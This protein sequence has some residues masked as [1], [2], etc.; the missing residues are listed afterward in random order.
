MN[1]YIKNVILV[2]NLVHIQLHESDPF[3]KSF[4]NHEAL[5]TV[6][7][8]G[9]LDLTYLEPDVRYQYENKL[10]EPGHV[11][12]SFAL[13]QSDIRNR[14][15]EVESIIPSARYAAKANVIYELSQNL[16]NLLQANHPD[17]VTQ[18]ITADLHAG[19]TESN[20]LYQEGLDAV[21][22]AGDI[23][24]IANSGA[25]DVIQG[26]RQVSIYGNEIANTAN[27][28]K[29]MAK[30]PEVDMQDFP[31]RRTAYELNAKI[32]DTKE[33]LQSLLRNQLPG[34]VEQPITS[35]EFEAIRNDVNNRD[36]LFSNPESIVSSMDRI[37][38]AEGAI[39]NGK[40]IIDSGTTRQDLIIGTK[41]AD[42]AEGYLKLGKT[43][44]Q[45]SA[46]PI[47]A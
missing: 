4:F 44:I 24:S 12:D 7:V 1:I 42:L 33:L 25:R 19:L 10:V 36:H 16:V 30:P 3:Y 15:Q 28:I 32:V 18:E 8:A 9:I 17:L 43:L 14:F 11:S 23:K 39:T 47:C 34:N 45:K 13:V 41:S 38:D 29:R 31:E 20:V 22:G 40:V 5:G 35:I 46:L 27:S 6:G 21:I 26:L 2:E 37:V